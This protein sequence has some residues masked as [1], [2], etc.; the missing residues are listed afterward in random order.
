[1]WVWGSGG[2]GEHLRLR[3][4]YV[5]DGTA[6]TADEDH[7]APGLALHEVASDGCRKEVGTVDIDGEQLAHALD[8]VVGGLEVLGE[9]RGGDQVVNLAV[10]GQ[11]LGD[12]GMDAL[13]I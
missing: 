8:G 3:L 13:W 6:H 4:R 10:L 9:A 7:A 2:K 5:D 12:A 11:D 1:M